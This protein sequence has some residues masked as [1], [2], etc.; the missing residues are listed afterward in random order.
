MKGL[1]VAVLVVVM[2]TPYEALALS[3]IARM[4]DGQVVYFHEDHLGSANVITDHA[5]QV[6]RILEYQPYGQ[7]S[8]SQV[9]DNGGL[10]V[11]IGQQFTGQYHDVESQLYFYNA[12]Y[13]DPQLA[14]FITPD[15]V[16]QKA[17]WPVTLN[18]YAYVG[19]N[20]VVRTD[21]SGHIFGFIFAAVKA[22]VSF[23]IAHPV[24]V[25][26]AI[27]A[28]SG[29]ITA[30]RHD[31][32]IWQGIAVGAVQGGLAGY[33][34]GLTAATPGA[35]SGM[36]LLRL[37]AA[38]S[39]GA[40]VADA[41]D[42]SHLAQGL[43]F[44][45]TVLGGAYAG[46]NVAIGIREWTSGQ[47]NVMDLTGSS[48]ALQ[49]GDGVFVNGILTDAKHAIEQ[50][51][52]FARNGIPVTKIAHNPTHGFIAD[53]TESFLQKLTFTSSVDRQLAGKIRQLGNITLSGHSQGSMIVGNA[54]LNLGVNGGRSGVISANFLSTPLSQPRVL[55]S[56]AWSGVESKPFYGNNWGDP[57]NILGP[58]VNPAKF[59]SGFTFQINN[60]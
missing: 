18:R 53:M 1:F 20:P 45:S 17:G 26:G 15:E 35:G 48:S 31:S 54:L 59:L 50:A 57:I 52:Y 30:H 36:S 32:N 34:L 47:L 40:Q 23:A 60:H 10:D 12:R 27:S 8:R 22:L 6:R 11:N 55:L 29:G 51:K 42:E 43:R 37:S 9:F 44:G 28:V 38:A 39:L 41:V 56:T 13:Y 2:F 16:V 21:P 7:T 14:R 5:G 46:L 3:R 58:N 25:S 33:T 4:S 49:S 19:N 24:L